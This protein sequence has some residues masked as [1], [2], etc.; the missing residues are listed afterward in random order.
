MNSI[1]NVSWADEAIDN[2]NDVINY[3]EQ[4]WS[5]KEK[6]D[7]FKKLEKR[8]GI[9][10]QYPEI[11][12]K[13]QKSNSVYRSVLTEQITIYYSV[14][15]KIIKILSLFDVRQDPSKLKI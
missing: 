12:P 2:L 3:L 6:T 11:F 14:E 1:Y 5:Y 13:S 15:N 8:L 7:F 9:I 10:K 4:N